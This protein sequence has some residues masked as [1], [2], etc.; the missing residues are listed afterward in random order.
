MYVCVGFV[1]A[2]TSRLTSWTN[3]K[4]ISRAEMFLDSDRQKSLVEEFKFSVPRDP[5]LSPYFASDEIL[6]CLPPIRI[7]VSRTFHSAYHL[8]KFL[9]NNILIIFLTISLLHESIY[10]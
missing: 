8:F 10:Y 7:L 2:L 3:K 4:R 9:L 6:K 5:Y 1:G